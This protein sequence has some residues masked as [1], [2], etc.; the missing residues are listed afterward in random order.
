M[1]YSYKITADRQFAPN[2]Y[3]VFMTFKKGL[4]QL[5]HR[6]A[7]SLAFGSRSAPSPLS[8]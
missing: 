6:K 2:P 7:I 1:L 8:S 4:E 5:L 3:F